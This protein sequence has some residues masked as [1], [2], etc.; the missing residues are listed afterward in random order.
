M[1]G[2]PGQKFKSGDQQLKVNE[3]V[4]RLVQIDSKFGQPSVKY[5]VRGTLITMWLP[6]N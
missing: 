2:W 6:H 3:R 1:I 5:L 4:Y